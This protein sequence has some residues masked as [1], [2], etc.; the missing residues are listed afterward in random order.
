MGERLLKRSQGSISRKVNIFENKEK[1]P[2]LFIQ[3]P[4]QPK[5]QNNGKM[6]RNVKKSNLSIPLFFVNSVPKQ[7]HQQMKALAGLTHSSIYSLLTTGQQ[8]RSLI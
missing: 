2:K 1:Q 5:L 4:L 7:K 3:L 8:T 6:E